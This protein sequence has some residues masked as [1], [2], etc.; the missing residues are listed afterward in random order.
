MKKLILVLALLCCSPA[1]AQECGDVNENGEV[2]AADALSVLQSAVGLGALSC[3]TGDFVAL[4]D[5]VAALEA[6][7]V[8]GAAAVCSALTNNSTCDL[9]D[10][11]SW[12]KE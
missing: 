10:T 1:L 2:T 5:R 6:I 9:D 12:L 11:F 7:G 8:D 4:E 3:R